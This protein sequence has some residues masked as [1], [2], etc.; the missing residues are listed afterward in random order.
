MRANRK[1]WALVDGS[2]MRTGAAFVLRTGA[3]TCA[4]SQCTEVTIPRH[5]R[6]NERCR[7]TYDR[8]N[9]LRF[10]PHRGRLQ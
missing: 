10:R 7:T 4:T 1:R 9:G 8:A 6:A 2:R 5:R 3:P